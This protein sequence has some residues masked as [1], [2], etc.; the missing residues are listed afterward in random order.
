MRMLLVLVLLAGLALSPAWSAPSITLVNFPTW[1]QSVTAANLQAGT[2]SDV[3][4][5]YDS[6]NGTID[7]ATTNASL[8]TISVSRLAVAIPGDGLVFSFVRTGDG[9]GTGSVETTYQLG[10]PYPI[11]TS[12][13]AMITGK[14]D[15]TGITFQIRISSVSVTLPIGTYSTK[16]TLTIA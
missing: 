10:T 3:A 11:P 14:K 15:R 13:Q 8:W 12:P 9:T 1:I 4:N 6:T 16:I 7:V 2:G 5:T